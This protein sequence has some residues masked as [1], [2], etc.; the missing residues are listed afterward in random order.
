MRIIFLDC[1]NT[2][3][4]GETPKTKAL[5]GIESTTVALAEAFATQD[6]DVTVINHNKDNVD[7]CINAVKWSNYSVFDFKDQDNWPDIVIANNNARLFNHFPR[8]FLNK[9][10]QIFLWL[11]NPLSL[12]KTLKNKRLSSIIRWQPTAI[13]LGQKQLKACSFLIP[14]KRRIIIPH[15]IT[16]VFILQETASEK[17]EKQAVYFSQAYRGFKEIVEL[18]IKYVNSTD[19]EAKLKAYIGDVNLIELGI[20]YDKDELK[21]FNIFL[22]PK[23]SKED[24]IEDLKRSRCM[25]YTG[26]KHETFCVA[27]IEANALGVPIVSYGRGSLSE[28]IQN[29]VNGFLVRDNNDKLFADKT[30]SLLNDDALWR[31]M[32]CHSVDHVSSLTWK[33]AVQK[34]KSYAFQDR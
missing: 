16:E 2:P 15:A 23:V 14:F 9:K 1:T 20:H 26:H 34:W 3:Y 28:R 24:L 22:M 13:F 18:W 12:L 19:Q 8:E 6:Y 5:G 31:T 21:A 7:L 25:V 32:S 29:E 33:N 27:A 4:N 10:P 11:H 30:L 17:R